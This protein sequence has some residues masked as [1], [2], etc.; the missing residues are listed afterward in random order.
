[1]IAESTYL[2]PT[3]LE[4]AIQFSGEKENNFRYI[5]GGTDL[6][7]NKF[8]ENEITNCLIDI[9]EIEELKKVIKT[10]KHL[11]IGSLVKLE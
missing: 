10:E 8:Q 5:A 1:M 9:T 7:V 3:S 2:K 11:K 4:E 6:I